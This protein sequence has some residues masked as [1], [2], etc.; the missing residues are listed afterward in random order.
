[1]KAGENAEFKNLKS[2]INLRDIKSSYIINN[3]FSF[4]KKRRKLQMIV[5]NKELQNNCL[6]GSNEYR[7]ISWKYKI[8]ERNGKGKEYIINTHILIFEGEYLNGKRNGKG[9]EYN[10]NGKLIFEGEYLNGKRNG[11]GKEY[12]SNGKLKY[13]GE[14]LNG[15]RNVK[16]KEH[17]FFD[18][19]LEFEGEYLN[20][21]RNG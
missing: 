10:S 6:I 14:Y 20:G 11:K 2:K 12:D 1:M 13:E 8:G 7:K 21:K 17:N 3:I 4:L 19:K 16:V 18:G 15:E 5:Y 9:K